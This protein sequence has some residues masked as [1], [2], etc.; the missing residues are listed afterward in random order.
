MAF[1]YPKRALAHAACGVVVRAWR[2]S[3]V[4]SAVKS[5][6]VTGVRRAWRSGEDESGYG[7]GQPGDGLFVGPAAFGGELG[8]GAVTAEGEERVGGGFGAEFG[9]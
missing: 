3:G 4:S 8:V 6:G 7:V 1:R 2:P 9:P 5:L